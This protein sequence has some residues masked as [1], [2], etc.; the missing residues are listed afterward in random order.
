MCLTPTLQPKPQK[1]CFNDKIFASTNKKQIKEKK[2]EIF[3]NPTMG[4]GVSR[5][6]SISA[7]DDLWRRAC[8]LLF[9]SPP[10][11]LFGLLFPP[12]SRS[13]LQLTQILA[14]AVNYSFRPWQG[15]VCPRTQ[16]RRSTSFDHWRGPSFGFFGPRQS[17]RG[18]TLP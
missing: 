18:S 12:L 5:V 4:V 8:S 14:P 17:S 3:L 10:F 7:F 16:L 9:F 11:K 1:N 13:V 15:S 2:T 6:T